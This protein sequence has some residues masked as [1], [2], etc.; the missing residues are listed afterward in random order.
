MNNLKG[1]VTME[2]SEYNRLLEMARIS[3]NLFTVSNPYEGQVRVE[4]NID[5]VQDKIE[6]M[7]KEQFPLAVMDNDAFDRRWN[8]PSA[9]I[10]KL[11]VEETEEEI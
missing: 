3:E 2:L 1:K 7:V 10:A 11:P 8:L 5:G 9:N 4:V 6:R